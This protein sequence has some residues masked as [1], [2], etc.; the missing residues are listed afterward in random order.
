M[1]WN[2]L[3]TRGVISV[4]FCARKW[5][6]CREELVR[7]GIVQITDRSYGPG[8]A[9]VW[10]VGPFFP[11]LGLWKTLSQLSL[12]GPGC[13]NRIRKRNTTTQQQNTLL[14][15]RQVDFPVPRPQQP[16]RPPPRRW[17]ALV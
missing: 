16:S 13:F 8:K 2:A 4:R 9:M 7:Y 10:T 5:A 17:P 14:R 11:F 1:I 3:Y 12:L 6:V 15:Q